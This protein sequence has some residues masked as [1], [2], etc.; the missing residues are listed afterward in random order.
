MCLDVI[1]KIYPKNIEDGI[2]DKIFYQRGKRLYGEWINNFMY[3]DNVSFDS[4]NNR[5]IGK[6]LKEGDYRRFRNKHKKKLYSYPLEDGYSFGFHVFTRFE[7]AVAMKHT[8]SRFVIRKVQYKNVAVE[9]YQFCGAGIVPVIVA[10]EI[11]ILEE[12]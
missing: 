3:R 9:G 1:K 8:D 7:D 2:G 6:W 12:K 11:K 5:P 10:K 4:I